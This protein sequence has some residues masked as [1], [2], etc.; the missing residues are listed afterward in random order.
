MTRTITLCIVLLAG[1][2]GAASNSFA[3]DQVSRYRKQLLLKGEWY[4]E[5]NCAFCHGP[6]GRGLIG[7]NLT[8]LHF[9]YG[10]DRNTME[11]IIAEGLPDKG[12]PV[13]SSILPADQLASIKEYVWS[14]RGRM[15]E[16][17]APEGT[18]VVAPDK[19]DGE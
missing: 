11:K 8:D 14:L 16:G 7:P 18:P 1:L 12:M 9:I 10:N 5:R 13:W 17:K 3:S 19:V 2:L 15:L 6:E 4:F